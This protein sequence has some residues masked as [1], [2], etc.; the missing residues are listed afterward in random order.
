M[1][2]KFAVDYRLIKMIDE[3]LAFFYSYSATNI[4][5]ELDKK[6]DYSEMIF[7]AKLGEKI[8]KSK[9]DK[10]E[11]LLSAPRQHEMEEYYWGVAGTDTTTST[12]LMLVGMMTDEHDLIYNEEEDKVYLRLRR[13]K[14]HR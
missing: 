14:S 12:E 4:Q 10:V 1:K 11:R 13:Y 6:S 3:M 9:L 8:E 2:N 7:N 5:M